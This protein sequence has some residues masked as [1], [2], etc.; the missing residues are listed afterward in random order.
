MNLFNFIPGYNTN[1][2]QEGREPALVMLLAFILTYIL[3]RGYTRIARKTGWGSASFGGVHTH[4]MVFG[5]VIA[6]VS[7]AMVFAFSPDEGPF[8]LLLAAAFGGGA[9]LVLDEFALL[10]H[11]EDVYWEKEGRKSIDAIVISLLLGFVFL[12]QTP[13]LGTGSEDFGVPFFVAVAINLPFIIV[14]GLKGKIYFSLFGLF[15]PLLALIGSLRLA[16]PDSI[17]SKKFYNKSKKS[18]SQQRYNSYHKKWATKKEK[19]WDIIGGRTGRPPQ[20]RKY[21]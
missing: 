2:Y 3:A 6:F 14:A 9:A 17:W 8:L 18:K 10:F 7:G 16:K 21:K 19:L 12:M 5:M 15:V 4:H 11:L 1:V 13:P 20:K